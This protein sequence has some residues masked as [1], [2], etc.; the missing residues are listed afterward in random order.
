MISN[1][2]IKDIAQIHS[3]KLSKQSLEIIEKKVLDYVSELI[4][5]ASRKADFSGRVLILPS[6]CN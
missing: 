1:K 2:K 4:K 6:D 3:K 5:K